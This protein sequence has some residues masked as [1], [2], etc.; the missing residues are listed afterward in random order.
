[1]RIVLLLMFSWNVLAQNQVQ[2]VLS[3]IIPHVDLPNAE[4]QVLQR[5]LKINSLIVESIKEIQL[6]GGDILATDATVS[7]LRRTVIMATDAKSVQ[8]GQRLQTNVKEAIESAVKPQKLKGQIQKL[9]EFVTTDLQ[10]KGVNV[11]NF[12]R[13]YGVQVGLYYLAAMQVDY[14]IP[15]ILMATGN[16]KLGAALFSTPFSSSTT[17]LFASIRSATRYR[18]MIKKLGFK[19]SKHHYRIFRAVKK[20]FDRSYFGTDYLVDINVAG[21]RAVLTIEE[22]NAVGK[23]MNKLGFKKSINYTNLV[24]F[25]EE[26]NLYR[27]FI[28]RSATKNNQA[29][30][31]SV[32]KILRKIELSGDVELI[33]KLKQQF[34]KKVS[35]LEGIPELSHQKNWFIK[36][37]NSQSVDDV[38]RYMAKMPSDIAPRTFS[39]VWKGYVLPSLSNSFGNH[40][41]LSTYRA[42]RNLYQLYDSQILPELIGN[43]SYRFEPEL[44]QKINNYL[45]EGFYPLDSCGYIFSAPG[46]ALP[47][48]L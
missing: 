45:Y 48:F 40:T 8:I 23:L 11:S 13:R 35:F 16:V 32:V 14:T 39:K 6:N 42:F 21:T 38:F 34:G 44:K 10:K 33:T 25:L 41:S 17:A 1:M 7:N 29:K 31:A 2:E 27:G 9:I 24:E 12:T 5:D 15:L 20:F 28:R 43:N 46:K 4:F 36:V 22:S 47:A 18:H 26:N 30:L 3:E 19:A 37:A